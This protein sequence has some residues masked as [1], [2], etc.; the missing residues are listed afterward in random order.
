MASQKFGRFVLSATVL[1][2][3]LALCGAASAVVT[4]GVNVTTYHYDNLRTGWDQNET[5]LTP[6]AVQHGA[7]GQ[8]FKLTSFIGLDEQTDA[9]PL[10][11]T[12]ETITGKGVHDVVY[13]AT[14][15]NSVYAI[16]ANNGA[17]LLHKNYGPPVPISELPGGCNNNSSNVGIGG[18]P[19]IDLASNV[20]YFI[21]YTNT[22]NQPKLVLHEVNLTTLEDVVKIR[23]TAS[24]KLSNGHVMKL[25]EN[26]TR[27]RAAMLFANGNVYAGFASFCDVA[28]DQ[29]RGWLLGWNGGSLTPLAANQLNNRLPTS[30]DNFFLSSIWMSGYGLAASAAGDVYF[31]SGNSDYSGTTL[32]P[33]NN[34]AESAVQMS[35]DLST[36]KS[37]FT[38]DNAVDLENEDGDFGSG[39]LMLL[40]TVAGQASNF[41]VG[42]GKDGNMYFLNADNLHN[43]TTGANRVLGTY[44]IGGCWCGQSFFTG[45]DGKGRVVSSGNNSIGMWLVK[46]GAHPSLTNEFTSDGISGDQDPGFFTAIS[47]N[48]TTGGY[49]IWGVSRPNGSDSDSDSLYAFNATNGAVLFSGVAGYWTNTGGNANIAPVVANGHV[50]VATTVGLSIFGLSSAPA[51]TILVPNRAVAMRAP[52]MAGQHEFFG[53]VRAMSGWT[54]TVARRDGSVV[55]VDTLSAAQNKNFAQPRVGHGILVRGHYTTTSAMTADLVLHAKDKPVMWQPDR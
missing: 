14:E 10:V 51:A 45:H 52:L 9:Q 36:V 33:V 55:T 24:A 26:V 1:L 3:G 38:P 6:Q 29:S 7:G 31:I 43:N 12:G 5:L 32:D 35:G 17:V 28:A 42:A 23:I 13:V 11:V 16:D 27:Q 44:N 40:P 50:Y 30:P 15:N 47:S 53:T 34:I 46:G 8:T 4:A 25:N 37:I 2:G 19:V 41:A 54:V 49:V 48:G 39:G 22:Q 21:A 18:T 20:M